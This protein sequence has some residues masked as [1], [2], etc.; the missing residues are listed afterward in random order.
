MNKSRMG[1]ATVRKELAPLPRG[2]RHENGF[3]FHREEEGF[4]DNHGVLRFARPGGICPILLWL[5][6]IPILLTSSCTCIACSLSEDTLF[7]RPDRGAY[8]R[9]ARPGMA[10]GRLV[11]REFHCR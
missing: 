5:G 1:V 6:Q 2:I 10:D 7:T 4:R 8:P 3:K 11:V 9:I